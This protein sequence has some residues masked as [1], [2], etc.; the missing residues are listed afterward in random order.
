[1]APEVARQPSADS[2]NKVLFPQHPAR[3]MRAGCHARVR[4]TI[5]V[6]HDIGRVALAHYRDL[7]ERSVNGGQIAR[8][9]LDG[10]RPDVFFQPMQFRGAGWCATIGKS[11]RVASRRN[12][13]RPIVVVLPFF[14]LLWFAGRV[15][16]GLFGFQFPQLKLQPAYRRTCADRPRPAPLRAPLA[17]P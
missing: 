12:V 10:S 17:T 8:R 5:D 14:F 16:P 3:R 11:A 6:P 4:S 15:A 9:Q 1:M 13:T 2:M 7:P